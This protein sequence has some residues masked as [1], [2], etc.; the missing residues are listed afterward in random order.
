MAQL[1]EST[2]SISMTVSVLPQQADIQ[3]EFT[4]PYLQEDMAGDTS[5]ISIFK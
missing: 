4:D 1:T 5:T 3:V 2:E